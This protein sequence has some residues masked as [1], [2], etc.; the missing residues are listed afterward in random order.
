MADHLARQHLQQ[1]LD[2][3]GQGIEAPLFLPSNASKRFVKNYL[4]GQ[5]AETA[6]ARTQTDWINDQEGSEGK[7]RY[8][9]RLFKFP[10]V[11]S[12]RFS[13]DALAI[14]KPLLEAQN[15]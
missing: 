8:W 3:Y 15:D 4:Q 7:D 9:Q 14:W 6:L 5:A 13:D 10:Q 12:D 11:F 2:Y 1:L